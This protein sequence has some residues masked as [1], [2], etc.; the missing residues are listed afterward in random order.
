[1]K[2]LLH[3]FPM[4]FLFTILSQIH[5]QDY[6]M[7]VEGEKNYTRSVFVDLK[8]QKQT[9]VDYTTWDIAFSTDD[10]AV[11]ILINEAVPTGED[12]VPVELYSTSAED[13][14]DVDTS[15]I[16]KILYNGETSNSQGAFNAAK[17]P[18]D[19]FDYGWG[20]YDRATHF[21]TGNRIFII[22]LRDQSY[23]KFRVAQFDPFTGTY[24]FEYADIESDEVTL[25]SIRLSE[26][27]GKSLVYYSLENEKTVEVEPDRWDLKFTR[28]NTP[29]PDEDEIL[30]YYVYGVLVRPGV[31]VAKV[32]DV[33]FEQVNY[34]DYADQLSG[35]LDAIGYDWKFI[36]LNSF[37]YSVEEDVVFFVKTEEGEVYKVQF[38]DFTGAS[39]AVTTIHVALAEVLTSNY[40]LPDFI[41]EA[42]VFP[43]PVTGERINLQFTSEITSNHSV[44]RIID[45][46]GREVYADQVSILTGEN[47]ISLPITADPG[48]Y[49]ISVTTDRDHWIVPFLSH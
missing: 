32:T 37:Q 21:L 16:I 2:T 35:D 47:R 12:A 9:Q 24:T 17:D 45:M 42:K 39:T 20:A 48:M 4:L 34:E 40:E 27:S 46:Q 7:E 14:S 33:N 13:F 31:E 41:K 10:R 44:I 6:F 38:I 30:D 11:S 43:N 5:S 22:R 49:L 26:Y 25:D 1:M 29:I 18:D 23:V 28:Y 19:P 3:L 8:N 36:D 15:Q